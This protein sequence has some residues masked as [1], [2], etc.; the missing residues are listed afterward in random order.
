ML[1]L[2]RQQ[3]REVDRLAIEDL[4]IPGIV[5]M[6]NAGRHTANAVLDLIEHELQLV[7]QD[8]SVAIFCGGGNNGGDGYV[9]AR[10]LQNSGAMVT[11]YAIRN[12]DELTGDAAIQCAIANKMGL[13]VLMHTP[14]QRSQLGSAVAGCQVIVDALLGTGFSG[15]VRD[16]LVD[17]IHTINDAADKGAKILAV[18][19][20]SGLDCDTGQPSGAEG[21]TTVQADVTV[22][23][24]AAKQG[25]VAESAEPFVGELEVVDIGAPPQLIQQV[26]PAR[27]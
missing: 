25:L 12:P 11:A 17:V 9:I 20:P 23:F 2:T 8:A 22:T 16:E 21:D 24:V 5:L 6:E 7:A 13:V 14:D 19:I 27:Q 26:L 10:H 3:V 1:T 18:D 15:Q 4:G